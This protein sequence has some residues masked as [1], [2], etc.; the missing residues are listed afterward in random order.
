MNRPIKL[1][2]RKL[3][4]ARNDYICFVCHGEIRKGSRYESE[5]NQPEDENPKFFKTC[6]DCSSLKE[7]EN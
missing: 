2:F 3:V 5:C 4:K 1:I 6:L 7:V